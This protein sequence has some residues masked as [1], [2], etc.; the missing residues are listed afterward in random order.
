MHRPSGTI[1]EFP[2]STLQIRIPG[3][4]YRIPVAGGGYLRLFPEWIIR[5]SINYINNH[6]GQ[7]VVIYFHPWEIDHKQPRIKAGFKSRFR[8]YIN[9]DKT[10]GRVKNLLLTFNFAPME[11]VLGINV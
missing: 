3:I 10:L 2:M 11:E 4:K 1:K 9:L 6:E 8:H 7:P 5:K